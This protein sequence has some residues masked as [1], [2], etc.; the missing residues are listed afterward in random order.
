TPSNESP[1]GRSAAVRS[2]TMVRTSAAECP[3]RVRLCGGLALEPGRADPAER[4]MPASWVIEHLDVVKQ[5]HLR[6]AVAGKP[7]CLLALDSREEGL[8]H[9]VVV[10]VGPTAHTAR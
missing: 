5:R 6:V 9:G 3:P 2:S 4:R 10:A 8:H 7:L 1:T